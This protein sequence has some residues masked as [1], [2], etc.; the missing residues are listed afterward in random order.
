MSADV[1]EVYSRLAEQE[2]GRL[3]YAPYQHLEY[4]VTMHFLQKYL[5]ATGVI[6]DAGGG[7]GRYTLELCRQGHD[8]ELCDLAEGNISLAREQF[9]LEPEAVCSH[10]RGMQVA[11]IRALPYAEGQFSA[12][13]CLGGPLSHLTVAA[14]RAQAMRELVRV[15]APAG[16]VVL[17][18][19][20]KLAVMRTIM[21][22]CSHELVDGSL[23]TFFTDS[24]SPG[25]EG[26]LWHW[27]RAAELR[28]LAESFDLNTITMA[29]CQSLSTGLEEAT[30]VLRQNEE[31]WQHWFA[32]LLAHATEPAVVDMAEH[33]LYFGRKCIESARK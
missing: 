25:P 19:I 21:M 30:N 27:F 32:M 24:N 14:D 7:P 3:I 11:D 26:M 4:Q 29:G 8:V 6:L 28:D 15:T 16:L 23:E 10:L 17:S 12:V 22:F 20:G 5:P 2:F 1:A 31:K 9:A 33:I 18:G 13:L